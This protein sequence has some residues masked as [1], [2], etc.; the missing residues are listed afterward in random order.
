[1]EVDFV[2]KVRGVE[3]KISREDLKELFEFLKTMFPEPTVVKEYIPYYP[4]VWCPSIWTND[5][6]WDSTDGGVT[7]TC[8][9]TAGE[10][11]G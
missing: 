9:S 3:V 8:T 2:L 4:P 1:M 11:D 7:I 10:W 5:R 6:S